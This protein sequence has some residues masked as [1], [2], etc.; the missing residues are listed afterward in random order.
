MGAA[1]AG[2]ADEELQRALYGLTLSHAARLRGLL[3]LT[4]LVLDSKPSCKPSLGCILMPSLVLCTQLT[5]LHLRFATEKQTAG[6]LSQIGMLA[7]S[8]PWL[9]GLR[10]LQLASRSSFTEVQTTLLG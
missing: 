1:A 8:I 10:E 5:Q 7:K 2:G 6:L 9:P 3:P 4:S